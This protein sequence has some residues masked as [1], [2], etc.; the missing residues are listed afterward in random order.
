M[1]K[2]AFTCILLI[3]RPL[4][5]GIHFTKLF[6][7]DNAFFTTPVSVEDVKKVVWNCD[8]KLFPPNQD[9]IL[10]QPYVLNEVVLLN[11]VVNMAKK[12]HKGILKRD[13]LVARGGSARAEIIL[14]SYI[15]I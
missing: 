8:R 4:L 1:S 10:P 12:I 13:T 7:Q 5:D 15:C 11:E 14:L 2:G 3:I 9:V 6:S